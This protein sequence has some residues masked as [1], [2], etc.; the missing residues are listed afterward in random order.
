MTDH[1]LPAACNRVL[2]CSSTQL[3][4][5]GDG[6]LCCPTRASGYLPCC[7]LQ[8]SFDGLH[9][10]PEGRSD[11]AALRHCLSRLHVSGRTPGDT[12]DLASVLLCRYGR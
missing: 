7:P 2:S 6:A 3:G 11:A 8:C 1:S 4:L 9:C 10:L 5:I 12:P